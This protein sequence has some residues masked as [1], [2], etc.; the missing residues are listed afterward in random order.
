MIKITRYVPSTVEVT[1][2]F[3]C[4]TIEKARKLFNE[5]NFDMEVGENYDLDFDMI[6]S[7][8]LS[9]DEE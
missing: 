5:G 6:D 9:P 4:N 7:D 1:M 8:D 2:I 3:N